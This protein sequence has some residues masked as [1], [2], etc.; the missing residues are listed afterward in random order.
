MNAP[1]ELGT[2]KFGEVSLPPRYHAEGLSIG[3]LLIDSN[4]INI[5][6]AARVATYQRQ[7]GLRFGEAAVKLGLIDSKDVLDALARQYEYPYVAGAD[8]RLD[9]RLIVAFAPFSQR[10]E[11][12]RTLRSQ[13]MLR[14]F[15]TSPRRRTIAITGLGHRTGRTFVTANLGIAFSQ[16]GE[17][18]LLI[19]ADLRSPRLH[20]MF[21]LDGS[22]GLSGLLAGRVDASAVQAVPALHNLAVLPG[23]PVPPN[24][25][26]LLGRPAFT[27]LLDEL[28]RL[29]SVILIDTSAADG[30]SDALLVAARARGALIVARRAHTRVA[31]L[32]TLAAAIT[33][34]GADPVGSVLLDL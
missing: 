17:R 3:A 24:P 6:D 28:E 9:P 19:D 5:D 7:T 22:R 16:L 31:A 21:G 18:T 8:K 15:L 25:Q 2:T 4:K 1:M 30:S 29:F 20:E 27:E 23:G 10:A 14:W 34:S 26:E 13:L 12:I 11:A 32:R 33:D